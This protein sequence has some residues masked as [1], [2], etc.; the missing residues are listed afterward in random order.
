MSKPLSVKHEFAV[1]I[2][3]MSSSSHMGRQEREVTAECEHGWPATC[4]GV[5]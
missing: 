5:C 2:L 4:P 1:N 3:A